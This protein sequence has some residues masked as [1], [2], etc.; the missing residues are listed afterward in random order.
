MEIRWRFDGD[1]ME[2]RWY[3]MDFRR[4]GTLG[5]RDLQ[6]G[7]E[8]SRTGL[9]ASETPRAVVG[10]LLAIS[11]PFEAASGHFQEVLGLPGRTFRPP[12]TKP[13]SL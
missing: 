13:K 12:E 4:L 8:A 9:E 11:K 5:P 1:S 10:P 7:P 6:P 3:S 2:I